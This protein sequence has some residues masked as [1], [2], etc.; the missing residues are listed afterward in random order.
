ML[1]HW[2]GIES[3][4]T[5]TWTEDLS[6]DSWWENMSSTNTPNGKAMASLTMLTS[7]TIWKEGISQ[8]IRANVNS[9]KVDKGGGKVL[10]YRGAKNMR[11]ILSGE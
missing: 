8:Q 9:S 10:G 4:D 6:I 1:K 5:T 11:L 2:L 7:W 3:I